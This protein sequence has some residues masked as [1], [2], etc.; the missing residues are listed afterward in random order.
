MQFKTKDLLV[1][2]LPQAQLSEKELAKLCLLRT[3]V[4]RY[5]TFCQ[6]GSVGCYFRPTFCIGCTVIGTLCAACSFQGTIGC[7][8]GL[9]CGG[10]SAC[11]PT[12]PCVGGSGDPWVLQRPEDLA[13]LK[14]ELQ[15]TIKSLDALEKEGL[16]SAVGSKA[17]ADSLER[18]LSE[19]LDQVRAAK[20]NLS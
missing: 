9:S 10:F 16:P 11:D 8:F 12:T 1:T 3:Y 2:V 7:Q 14:A 5:P 4:C 6:R 15:A 18:G 17:E 20:K 13:S 19:A